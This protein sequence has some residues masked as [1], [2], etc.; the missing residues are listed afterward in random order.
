MMHVDQALAQEQTGGADVTVNVVAVVAVGIAV[1][2]TVGIVVGTLT[3]FVSVADVPV[4][5]LTPP[6]TIVVGPADVTDILVV[7]AV[8]IAV[9]E[10]DCKERLVTAG[11]GL[12]VVR[13][14]GLPE[15][16]MTAQRSVDNRQVAG[17]FETGAA[18]A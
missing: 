7:G 9:A 12:A 16:G 2:D 8:T 18:L 3:E 11:A 15:F 13:S 4:T 6:G 1:N 10:A 5:A 17:G 14:N